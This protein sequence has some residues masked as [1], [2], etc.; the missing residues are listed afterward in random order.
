MQGPALVAP[1]GSVRQVAGDLTFPN[2]MAITADGATLL[3]AESHGNRITAYDISHEGGPTNRRVWADGAPSALLPAIAC[4]SSPPWTGPRSK[5]GRSSG[6]PA[7]SAGD[8]QGPP[9]GGEP[10]PRAARLTAA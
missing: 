3:V 10:P 5:S 9:H 2:G 4:T 8:A 6:R 1:D 7:L